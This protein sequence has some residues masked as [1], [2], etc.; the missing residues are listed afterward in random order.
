MVETCY[1]VE[2]E[3]YQDD[4]GRDVV[5]ISND[6]SS[7]CTY[8]YDDENMLKEIIHDY[9]DEMLDYDLKNK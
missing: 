8:P 3:I 5:Y 6:G 4:F 1:N 7:G 9:I 2:I